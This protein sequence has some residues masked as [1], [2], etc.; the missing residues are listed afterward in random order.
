MIG[1]SNDILWIVKYFKKMFVGFLGFVMNDEFIIF[2]FILKEGEMV[3][4]KK[5]IFF[6]KI[7]WINDWFVFFEG[8]MK[9]IFVEFLVEVVE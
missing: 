8:G 7:F 9:V 4:F 3:M 5:E 2:G 1:N 6:V